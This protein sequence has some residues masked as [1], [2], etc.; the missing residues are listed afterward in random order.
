MVKA[1][2][3]VFCTAFFTNIYTHISQTTSPDIMEACSDARRV[4]LKQG[5]KGYQ[6][7]D[8]VPKRASHLARRLVVR[9]LLTAGFLQSIRCPLYASQCQ[10]QAPARSLGL[11]LELSPGN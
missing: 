6:T 2:L 10:C 11:D 4:P 8:V 5:L 3:H 1:A 9:T 7:V